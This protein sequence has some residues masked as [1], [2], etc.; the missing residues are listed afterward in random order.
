[1]EWGDDFKSLPADWSQ[2][3]EVAI[4]YLRHF[5]PEVRRR[6]KKAMR[7]G[8]K[9]V[10]YVTASTVPDK[11][12]I[13][14]RHGVERS[15]VYVFSVGSDVTAYFDDVRAFRRPRLFFIPPLIRFDA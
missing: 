6:T 8:R 1:M 12:W 3:V 7:D 5:D 15:A 2:L 10:I 13:V 11:D 14:L 9:I 4:D